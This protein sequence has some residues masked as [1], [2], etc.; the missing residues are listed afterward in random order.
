[1]LRRIE[2]KLIKASHGFFYFFVCLAHF[3]VFLL[4]IR[5]KI[6]GRENIPKK[7]RYIFAANHQNFYDGFFI[8]FVMG[9]LKKIS[10]V[11]A[12]RALKSRFNQI[13]ARLIGSVIIGNSI[14]EYQSAL[15]KL[16]NIL[17][18]GGVVGIFPE[19][20]VSKSKFPRKFKGGVAKL[21]IDSKTK[22][23]PVYIK[24]TYNLRYLNFWFKRP[25]IVLKIGKP[26]E[27]Y[28]YANEFGNDL[29]KLAEF[30]REKVVELGGLIDDRYLDSVELTEPRKFANEYKHSDSS[31]MVGS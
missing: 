17:S 15:R 14:E 3:S 21:S 10:F 8:A 7:G 23:I 6:L 26:I 11:I 5:I 20:D 28:S 12:K 2:A 22:V 18:H 16:N 29:D 4:F 1:M 9:L 13:L 25:K 30:L 31:L 27:L 19:G 24:N